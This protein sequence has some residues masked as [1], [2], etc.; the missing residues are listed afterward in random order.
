MYIR[1]TD[2]FSEVRQVWNRELCGLEHTSVK[3]G[4]FY[5]KLLN[6]SNSI[7]G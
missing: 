4:V 2:V 3:I 5:T 6:S 1:E 7:S